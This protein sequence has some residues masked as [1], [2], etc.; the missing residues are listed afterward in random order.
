MPFRKLFGRKPPASVQVLRID[1]DVDGLVRALKDPSPTVVRDAA[2]AIGSLYLHGGETSRNKAEAAGAPLLEAYAN[3]QAELA[4]LKYH[5]VTEKVDRTTA[6]WAILDAL[7]MIRA[8]LAEPLV[9]SLVEDD[10]A[11]AYL[12]GRAAAAL[13]RIGGVAHCPS[14]KRLLLAFD[15]PTDVAAGATVGLLAMGEEGA[16]AIQHALENTSRHEFAA[17]LTKILERESGGEYGETAKRILNGI[18]EEA[19]WQAEQRTAWQEAVVAKRIE[20]FPLTAK[21]A[22]LLGHPEWTADRNLI[23]APGGAAYD[24]AVATCRK[25]GLTVV[26]QEKLLDVTRVKGTHGYDEPDE[27]EISTYEVS[28][29]VNFESEAFVI[30][31]GRRERRRLI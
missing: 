28:A 7:G 11:D 21:L 20:A 3:Q 6:Q 13:G 19:A 25:L 1:E 8:S 15:T 29:D 5:Q 24:E 17:A 30:V 10:R 4:N 16:T 9:L 26:E 12:R 2:M 14:L 23:K 18:A 31:G 22:T 27:T